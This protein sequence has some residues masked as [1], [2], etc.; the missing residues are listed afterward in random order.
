MPAPSSVA[1][2]RFDQTVLIAAPP[3]VVF[4][5]FFSPDALRIWWRVVRSITTA[6]PFGV[7]AVEWTPTPYRDEVLGP[8]GGVF[9]G[10]VVDAQA[11]RQFL[12][13]DCWWLPPEGPAL[14]P[15]ALQVRCQTQG[16]GC[17]LHIRQD[18]GDP[19]SRWHRYYAVV[20][21]GWQTSLASLKAYAEAAQGDPVA[22]P[23]R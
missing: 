9:H 15:M 6:V 18:G 2:E 23:G 14:G 8:L 11:G 5:C 12:V 16:N 19:S 21:Q 4:D 13:A 7:Y 10:T 22:G 17:R 20:T 1:R 3:A